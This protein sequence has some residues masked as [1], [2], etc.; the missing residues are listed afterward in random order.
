VL[1]LKIISAIDGKSLRRQQHGGQSGLQSKIPV[2]FDA[3]LLAIERRVAAGVF[4]CAVD[5]VLILGQ[6]ATPTAILMS[7]Q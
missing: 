7:L 5:Q 6:M 1:N 3:P 4:D 2:P